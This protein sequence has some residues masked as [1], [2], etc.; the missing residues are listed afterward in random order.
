MSKE[1][2]ARDYW[3]VVFKRGDYLI[4]NRRDAEAAAIL[5]AHKDQAGTKPYEALAEKVRD[6]EAWRRQVEDN[7]RRRERMRGGR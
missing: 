1:R 2:D 3:R 4:R 7:R 5:A 6:P